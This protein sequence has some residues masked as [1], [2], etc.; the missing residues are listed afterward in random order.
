MH[1]A[2]HKSKKFQGNPKKSQ[3]IPPKMPRN[4]TWKILKITKNS[5][6]IQKFKQKSQ[7]FKKS[8]KMQNQK[9]NPKKFHKSHKNQK[10][11]TKITQIRVSPFKF[12]GGTTSLNRKSI[13]IKVHRFLKNNPS[14]VTTLCWALSPSTRGE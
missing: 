3:I 6:N 1:T 13:F 9:Q 12:L 8:Q 7:K 4:S 10:N 2:V 11:L 14:R 5:S